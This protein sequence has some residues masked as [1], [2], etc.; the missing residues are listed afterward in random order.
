MHRKTSSLRFAAKSRQFGLST[1]R[2]AVIASVVAAGGCGG[3]GGTFSGQAASI[4]TSGGTFLA[5]GQANQSL[6]ASSAFRQIP[7]QIDGTVQTG[8][9]VPLGIAVVVGDP[10]TVVREGSSFLGVNFPDGPSP[11]LVD[12]FSSG[13]V[14]SEVGAD[15][16][17]NMG[18]PAGTYALQTNSAVL[19][20]GSGNQQAIGQLEFV[21]RV[22]IDGT[23]T[24]PV[25]F[26]GRLPGEGETMSGA[27]L[28]ME[29]DP[30]NTLVDG[31]IAAITIEHDGG[32]IYQQ[33]EVIGGRVSF[34]GFDDVG[35]IRSVRNIRS[36]VQ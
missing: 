18:L 10:V 36:E 26:N 27:F 29:F 32:T 24:F 25:S 23:S 13:L 28:D 22:E 6:S 31:S 21:Y 1:L 35:E 3:S 7:V 12:G 19:I 4:L 33:R 8:V 2:L 11:I 9:N 17:G 34:S 30:R 14:L 16:N 15:L 20:G 5:V